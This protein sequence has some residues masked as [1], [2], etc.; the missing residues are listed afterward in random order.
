MDTAP[1]GVP[2]IRRVA[3]TRDEV[4]VPEV[5][6]EADHVVAHDVAGR[7][8][9]VPPPLRAPGPEDHRADRLRWTHPED[10]PEFAR[11]RIAAVAEPGTVHS[12]EI[13]SQ[14]PEGWR[15]YRVDVFSALDDPAVGAVLIGVHLL[16]S[17]D[18]DPTER[19]SDGSTPWALLTISQY[20]DIVRAVG[21]T[22]ELYGYSAQELRELNGLELVHADDQSRLLE[23]WVTV[24]ERGTPGTAFRQRVVRRDGHVAWVLTSLGPADL[25]GHVLVHDVDISN[26]RA[27]EIALRASE[28]RFRTLAES[29]PAAVFLCDRFGL[30]EFA[31]ER[32]ADLT[33]MQPPASLLH[34]L[35]APSRARWDDFAFPGREPG[36]GDDFEAVVDVGDGRRLLVRCQPPQPDDVIAGA[37]EDVTATHHWRDRARHDPLTGLLGRQAVADAI[38]RRSA[39]TEPD[40]QVAF[41]DLDGFK[42][43]NDHLGHEAGDVV[44]RA[45]A[46]AVRNAVRPEDVVGRWGGDEF[47]IVSDHLPPDVA[48]DL[49]GRIRTHLREVEADGIRLRGASIGFAP[50][51]SGDDA[52]TV[53]RRADAAMYD[54]KRRRR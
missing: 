30:L 4:A 49:A 38:E 48:A 1:T 5:L 26:Q 13:R 18:V 8:R 12:V 34:L 2:T 37:V 14:S 28:V 25:A 17:E 20:G 35:D 16:R 40:A 22:A 23:A 51:M 9:P 54:D 21:M 47:V 32:F 24:L 27:A 33:G 36:S 10:R 41:V 31:N 46:H 43:V 15:R 50:I 7:P 3:G 11:A 42:A 19:P 44:L 53:I 6:R 29:A 39:L 52:V 45:A